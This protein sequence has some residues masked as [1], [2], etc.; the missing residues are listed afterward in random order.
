[1]GIQPLRLTVENFKAELS[2]LKRIVRR[3][4]EKRWLPLL[5]ATCGKPLSLEFKL[6]AYCGESMK[7]PSEVI[8]AKAYR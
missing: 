5:R 1:M 3:I 8:A 4:E 6:C 7:L 2:N